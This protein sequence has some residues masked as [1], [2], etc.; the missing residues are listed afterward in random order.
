MTAADALST[1]GAM[2]RQ[3][4]GVGGER[5]LNSSRQISGA[6]RREQ[7]AACQ[8]RERGKLQL[9]QKPT[10]RR[11]KTRGE[12]PSCASYEPST[13]F[14]SNMFFAAF[15]GSTILIH[16]S[17]R[18]RQ[19]FPPL[20]IFRQNCMMRALLLRLNR[21][22][23]TCGKKTKRPVRPTTSAPDHEAAGHHHTTPPALPITLALKS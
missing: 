15:A 17:Y 5:K 20:A 16:T 23:P 8:L 12:R 21:E 2:Y 10:N 7:C 1:H 22:A 4:W 11:L 14:K 19:N 13:R 9:S 3:A 18:A 6:H